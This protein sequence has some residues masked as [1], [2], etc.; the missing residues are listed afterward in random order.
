MPSGALGVDNI[1]QTPQDDDGCFGGGLGVCLAQPRRLHPLLLGP[2]RSPLLGHSPRL[3]HSLEAHGTSVDRKDR[4]CAVSQALDRTSPWHSSSTGAENPEA[5]ACL[6]SFIYQTYWALPSP[7]APQ[8]E[9]QGQ[10]QAGRPS[11]SYSSIPHALPLL[12]TSPQEPHRGSGL[13]ASPLLSR[14]L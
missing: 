10:T 5:E 7:P 12:N 2:K 13:T 3:G 4:N 6:H 8:I 1:L 14:L 11:R 9:T